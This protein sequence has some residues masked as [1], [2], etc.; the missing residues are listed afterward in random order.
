MREMFA[1]QA[2]VVAV[3]LIDKDSDQSMAFLSRPLSL[4]QEQS[5]SPNSNLQV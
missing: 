5:L 3:E 1:L 4:S 2:L